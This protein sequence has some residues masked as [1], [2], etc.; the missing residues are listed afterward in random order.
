MPSPVLTCAEFAPDGVTCA[1]QVWIEPPTLVPNL[2]TAE[3]LILLSA[4]AV[5]FANAWAWKQIG[6]AIRN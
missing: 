2:T 6:K 1:V 3:S 4:I 5:V